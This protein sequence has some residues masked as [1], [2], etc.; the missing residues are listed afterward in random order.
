[1]YSLV[2]RDPKW[3]QL[4][5][6]DTMDQLVGP[7]VVDSVDQLVG[8]FVVDSVDQFVLE[9]T[10]AVDSGFSTLILMI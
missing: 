4:W 3:N 2:S 5:V 10:R 1:M 6:V 7:C 9:R 8:L